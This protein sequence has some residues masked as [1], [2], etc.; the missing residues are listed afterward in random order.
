MCF[1]N[2]KDQ[3]SYYHHVLVGKMGFRVNEEFLTE[4][5]V[6]NIKRKKKKW[7]GNGLLESSFGK[8]V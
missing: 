6:K 8:E 4:S 7:G 3:Y 5:L 2:I 1:R